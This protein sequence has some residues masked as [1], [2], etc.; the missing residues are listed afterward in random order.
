M[1]KRSRGEGTIYWSEARQKWVVQLPPSQDGRRPLRTANTEA[2][3]LK[4]KRQMEA[5]RAA[6]RDLSRRAETVKELL[7]DYIE[8]VG[9]QVRASTL[10]VYTREAR[11]ITNRIGKLRIDAVNYE[12]AQRLANA[13][14]RDGY[15]ARL[16]KTVLHRLR[17]AYERVVP[18]R[19]PVNPVNWKRLTLRKVVQ[20]ERE[21][22]DAAQLRAVL[23]AADDVQARGADVRYSAAWWLAGLLGLRRGEIAGLTWRDLDWKRGELRIRQGLASDGKK[24]FALG[25][26]KTEN[27]P[28]TLPVGPLLLARLK[29]QW[30]MQ[31]AERRHAGTAWREHGLIICEEDGRPL[32]SLQMLNDVMNRLERATSGIPHLHPHLLRHTCATLLSELG[33]SDAVIGA[34]L[35]HGKGGIITRRY[36][37]GTEKAKRAAVEAL[38]TF[39]FPPANEAAKEA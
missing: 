2:E 10:A 37:H 26:L 18:E 24:G 35:G 30:E 27:S 13:L 32:H 33:Y 25:P 28:R 11:H 16:V 17:T 36:V 3:A 15:S 39:L 9:H 22:L 19:V 6:G 23:R 14:A 38:E 20:A 8:T 7:D 29:Q 4:L 5:E 34:I 12:T 1:G 21:P 31:Q